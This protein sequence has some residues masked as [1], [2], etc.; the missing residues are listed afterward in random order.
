MC[1]RP[2]DLAHRRLQ[3][4]ED[5]MVKPL[6]VPVPPAAV[7]KAKEKRPARCAHCGPCTI[8]LKQSLCLP[9]G[10]SGCLSD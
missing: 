1:V 8:A 9:A 7:V 2:P 5:E 6:P 4:E 3:E 10:L